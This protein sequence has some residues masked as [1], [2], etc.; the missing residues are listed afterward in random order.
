MITQHRDVTE[1]I[2]CDRYAVVI[3]DVSVLPKRCDAK[4]VRSPERCPRIPDGRRTELA[5][6][7]TTS[8]GTPAV[9]QSFCRSFSGYIRGQIGQL[10]VLSTFV[11]MAVRWN[12]FTLPQQLWLCLRTGAICHRKHPI[13]HLCQMF[14]VVELSLASQSTSRSSAL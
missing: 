7:P 11:F 9:Q 13:A 10:H 14:Q 3:N 4:A 2:E 1:I 6:T 8:S 5:T 12:Y